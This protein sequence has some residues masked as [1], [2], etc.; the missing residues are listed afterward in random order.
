VLYCAVLCS[1][2]FRVLLSRLLLFSC[3]TYIACVTPKYTQCLLAAFPFRTIFFRP[4]FKLLPL[5]LCTA[6]HCTATAV[7][8]PLLP[9]CPYLY[10]LHRG[11]TPSV[12]LTPWSKGFKGDMVQSGNNFISTGIIKRTSKG[13]VEVRMIHLSGLDCSLINAS[14]RSDVLMSN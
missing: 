3:T 7:H 12:P 10:L 13:T 1:A 8:L 4:L 14:L 6:L 2:V 5:P 9:P 11:Q